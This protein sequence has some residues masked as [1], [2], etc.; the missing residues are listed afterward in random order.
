MSTINNALS[1]LAEQQSSAT[2]QPQTIVR[3]NV[4]P[5]K[6]SRVIWAIGGFTLS[7]GIGAWAVNSGP[8]PIQTSIV[9]SSKLTEFSSQQAAMTDHEKSLMPSNTSKI[10]DSADTRIFASNKSVLKDQDE[11][12]LASINSVKS[13]AKT[14]SNKTVAESSTP[15]ASV[16]TNKITQAKPVPKPVKI[17][18]V[19]TT[20][21]HSNSTHSSSGSSSMQVQ[22]V[23]LTHRQ[24]ADKAIDR[25]SKALEAN[26]FEEATSEYQTALRFVSSDET[27]RRKLAALYY[28]NRQ[29]RKSAELLEEGIKL[30]KNSNDLRM[31]LATILMKEDQPEA[32]LSALGYIPDQASDKYLAT[33]AALAQKLKK[34][35][36]ALQSYQMLIKRDPENGRWWLGLGIQQ[37]RSGQPEEALKSYN[38]ALTMVGLSSQSQAFIRDRIALLTS[39][40]QGAE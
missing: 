25:A 33:R 11:P 26:D 15:V 31:S 24:M 18:A 17:A 28:G 22:Q 5:V 12:K 36:W 8:A 37:E 27:V 20:S 9:D 7:L 23:E 16:P 40:Q 13:T 14:N 1:K 34:N 38:S 32:A 19:T 29:V 4:S 2:D 30:N 3:A 39:I 35:E 21:S 6:S 10:I